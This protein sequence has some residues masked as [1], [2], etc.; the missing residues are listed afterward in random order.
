M[1]KGSLAY[2]TNRDAIWH[3]DVPKKYLRLLEH[4]PGDRIL[5]LGSAEGVLALVLAQRKEKIFALEMKKDRHEEALQ[6]QAH[7]RERGLD[8]DR[9]EM[10]LG[11]IKERFDLLPQV[12][13]LLGVRSIYY[14]REDVQRVFDAVG[15]HVKHVV[16]CG[17]KNRARRYFDAN[18]MPGDKLGT[19]NYYASKEGMISILETSGYS[20]VKTVDDGDPIVVGVKNV[21]GSHVR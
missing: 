4:V 2:R 14:L 10:I 12:D 15:Q 16:L 13:T 7:W 8:V 20:I 9:C 1:L 21:K 18:G 11:N 5:E 6:L 3:A 17:N 19:Y